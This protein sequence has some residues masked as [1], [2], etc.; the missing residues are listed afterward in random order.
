[1]ETDKQG[2]KMVDQKLRTC[3]IMQHWVKNLKLSF[4]I[5]TSM[6]KVNVNMNTSYKKIC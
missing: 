3:I 1:M 6:P 4:L 2:N 5:I